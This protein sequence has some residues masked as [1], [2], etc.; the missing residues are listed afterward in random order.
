MEGDNLKGSVNIQNNTTADKCQHELLVSQPTRII[1]H[2][3][4]FSGIGG[5]ALAARNVWKERYR[6]IAF[7]EI[8][9]YPQKVL[10]KNFGNDVLIIDDIKELD[11]AGFGEIDL[12]TG[13]FPCQDISAA[14]K[15]A[16]LNGK[17]SGLFF[18]M[19]RVID[20]SK[21]RFLIYENSSLVVG[22]MLKVI[23]NELRNLGYA[24]TGRIYTA[25]EFGFP[26]K[27]ER[28]YGISIAHSCGIG[29]DA[30]EA[31]LRKLEENRKASVYNTGKNRNAE[32]AR[33][34]SNALRAP[35]NSDILRTFDGIPEKLD[36]DRIKAL[37]NAIVP[38]IAELILAAVKA[39]DDRQS[40]TLQTRSG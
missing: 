26:H 6:T 25:R 9:E 22:D 21:P 35:S 27:R 40:Q 24:N 13:G 2:L 33:T 36:R 18:E 14:G 7:C 38:E 20:E 32:F 16:G 5:F 11:G 39:V 17:R 23:H 15:R 31:E 30:V 8:E 34:F 19:I 37:G 12:L 28:Y 4:L 1:K 10:R 3:D 29:W